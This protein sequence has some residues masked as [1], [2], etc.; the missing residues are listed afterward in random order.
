MTRHETMMQPTLAQ[1]RFVLA[2]DLD[3]TFLGGGAD[4]RQAFYSWIE[5][6]RNQIGLIFVTGRDPGFITDLT[7]EGGIPKPDYVVGDVG[8]TIANVSDAHEIEPIS[9]LEAPIAE[10][11][12][13][14]SQNVLKVLNGQPGLTLQA[15]PFR[16]RV[17]YNLDPTVFDRARIKDIERLGLDVLISDDRFLDVLPPG[18][19]K[20]PSLR[21]LL[22]HLGVASKKTLVAGDTL[23]DL[24]MLEMGL[25]AVAVGG[26]EAGLIARVKGL[27]HVH[28]AS[29]IGVAGIAE[30]ITAFNLFPQEPKDL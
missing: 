8:T 14:A 28:K 6:H 7:R 22:D 4:A 12:A 30:A 16:H 25:P 18:V 20:G 17:S 11:W 2:T 24:S 27:A 1:K 15:T 26:S 10:A 13:N 5:S 23:N 3:G 9:V 29:G 19:S 21:R